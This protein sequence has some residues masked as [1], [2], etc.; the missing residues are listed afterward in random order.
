MKRTELSMKFYLPGQ[1]LTPLFVSSANDIPLMNLILPIGISFY[2]FQSISYIIDIYRGSLKPTISI[3]QYG[4]F[5]AFFPTL[6]AGPILR[7]SDFLPQ[8]NEKV[9]NLKSQLRLRQFCG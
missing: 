8:L 9:S 7:A 5:V 4:L 2:T 6:V 3:F 1:G